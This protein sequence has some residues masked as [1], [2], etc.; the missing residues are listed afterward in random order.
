MRVFFEENAIKHALSDVQCNVCG[1]SVCKDAIGYFEDH[2]SI[3]KTWGYHSPYDGE[4]HSMDVCVDCYQGWINTFQIPPRVTEY[5]CFD[6]GLTD[7]TH[8]V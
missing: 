7:Y 5:S 2:V 8:V 4:I 3:S 6:Y 1:R